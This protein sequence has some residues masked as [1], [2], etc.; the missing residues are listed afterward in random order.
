MLN[1]NIFYINKNI[2]NIYEIIAL[3]IKKYEFDNTKLTNVELKDDNYIL[4]FSKTSNRRDVVIF[5]DYN[6][7]N[8]KSFIV[9]TRYERFGALHIDILIHYNHN[10]KHKYPE[11]I[12]YNIPD[13]LTNGR[14]QFIGNCS[15]DGKE[16]TRAN[17]FVSNIKWIEEN[18]INSDV[19]DLLYGAIRFWNIN[20]FI[21][22]NF[23]ELIKLKSFPLNIQLPLK[24]NVYR[25]INI[26]IMLRKNN[27]TD[28][29]VG[30]MHIKNNSNSTVTI[31]FGGIDLVYESSLIKYKYIINPGLYLIAYYF[32]QNFLMEKL[33][34]MAE[35]KVFMSI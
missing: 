4:S 10:Y 33:E 35:K 31:T 26:L 29:R 25:L 14:I 2:V 11:Y 6:K 24:E 18:I 30:P 22:I 5:S 1:G 34:L 28:L 19:I 32:Q 16:F 13:Y 7:N 17:H 20:T 3:Y 27:I 9:T 12:R 15:F 23:N 21:T 8:I